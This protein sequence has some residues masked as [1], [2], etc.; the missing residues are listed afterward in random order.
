[1]MLRPALARSGVS[2]MTT[3]CATCSC[4]PPS[5]ALVYRRQF[6]PMP[7]LLQVSWPADKAPAR[8]ACYPKFAHARMPQ[9][10]PARRIS[11]SAVKIAFSPWRDNESLSR[12]NDNHAPL[13]KCDPDIGANRQQLCHGAIDGKQGADRCINGI[14]EVLAEDETS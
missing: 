14:F 10:Y 3:S 8:R 11:S 4:A 5:R 6:C 12:R 13:R 1:M 7:H 2:A 9:E